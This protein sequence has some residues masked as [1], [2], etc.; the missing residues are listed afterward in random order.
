MPSV[1]VEG[2][3]SAIIKLNPETGIDVFPV[4]RGCGGL[5]YWSG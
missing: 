5:F 2:L 1:G 3:H 4:D